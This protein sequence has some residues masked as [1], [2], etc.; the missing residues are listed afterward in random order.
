[1]TQSLR[2]NLGLSERRHDSR[3]VINSVG[4]KNLFWLTPFGLMVHLV[5]HNSIALVMC[6]L[7]KWDRIWQPALKLS[8]SLCHHLQ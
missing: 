4:P 3:P 5:L 6:H 8:M 1:M 2:M 7:Q